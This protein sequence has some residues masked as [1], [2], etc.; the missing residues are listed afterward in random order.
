M[1]NKATI[2]RCALDLFYAKGYD[3]AG[4]QEIVDAAGITKP[5]LY[6]YFGSKKG[7]LEQVLAV[8]Y[9]IL[10]EQI[11]QVI[12]QKR[13]VP[14]MLYEIAQAFF[15][16]GFQNRKSYL[17]MLALFYSGRESEGFKA[18]YPLVQRFCKKVVGMFEQASDQLGNMNGRQKDFAIGFIGILDHHLMLMNQDLGD[19][20]VTA[21]S[22]EQTYRIVHQFMYG[23]FS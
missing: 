13:Q 2:L 1:D 19:D 23:I 20:E 5:T 6:Y 3:G 17:L 15:D 8:Y 21:I 11:D 9:T 22:D 18:V 7:L 10:E 12:Q 14:E 16:F 4:V